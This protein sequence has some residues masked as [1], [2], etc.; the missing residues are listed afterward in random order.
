MKKNSKNL[1]ITESEKNYILKMYGILKEQE[2]GKA[3]VQQQKTTDITEPIK[4]TTPKPPVVKSIAD[5]GE[6]K[7]LLSET[8]TTTFTAGFY[9]DK[10]LDKKGLQTLITKVTQIASDPK[11][12]NNILEVYVTVE[13]GESKSPNWDR[14]QDPTGTNPKF[15]MNSGDLAKRRKD[16]IDKYLGSQLS[17]VLIGKGRV[18]INN[19]KPIIGGPEWDPKKASDPTYQQQLK[20]AQFVRVRIDVYV[21]S[22]SF[23]CL[24]GMTVELNYETPGDHQCNN[25]VFQIYLNDILITR[26]D[27]KTYGNLNNKG[28]FDEKPNDVGGSRFNKFVVSDQ[29]AKQII[30]KGIT[31]DGIPV[32]IV[33]RNAEDLGGPL[34][35]SEQWGVGCHTSVGDIVIIP[36]E[37]GQRTVLRGG[38]PKDRGQSVIVGGFKPCGGKTFENEINV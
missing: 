4:Q 36:N 15:K 9:S 21:T 34:V 22:K 38:T 27:G 28:I 35:N 32:K 19:V 31:Q 25:A 37:T 3:L 18:Y 2:S 20:S 24:D 7:P 8:L 16:T 26:E 13:A 10:Y 33:C 6:Q 17:N 29:Q 12:Q 23:S 11:L 5:K 30:S 14:E 1:L